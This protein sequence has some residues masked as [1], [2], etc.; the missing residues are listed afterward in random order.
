MRREIVEAIVEGL[1]DS[2][3]FKRV[4]K[5]VGLHWSQIR[6]FPAAAVIYESEEKDLDNSTN[7]SNYFKGNVQIILYNKQPKTSYDDIL[8][9]LIDETYKV[10]DDSEFLRCNTISTDASSFK[11][12]GGLAW[13]YA[14][15]VLDLEVRF[16]HLCSV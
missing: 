5:N 1:E 14:V 12:D 4:Y 13:P 8:T 2:G 10:I 7:R 6:E 9:D 3:E 11:R 15:A 16:K